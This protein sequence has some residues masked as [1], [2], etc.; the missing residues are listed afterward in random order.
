MELSVSDCDEHVKA[1]SPRDLLNL[2]M[3]YDS[4]CNLAAHQ[5]IPEG[6]ASQSPQGMVQIHEKTSVREE[7]LT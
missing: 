7:N 3:A 4:E 6:N 2:S 1:L 5:T